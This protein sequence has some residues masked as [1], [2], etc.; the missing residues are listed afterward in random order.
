MTHRRMKAVA[1]YVMGV[2]LVIGCEEPDSVLVV[3]SPRR[4][5]PVE[6][7]YPRQVALFDLD[8]QLV[9]SEPIVMPS[10]PDRPMRVT[11]GVR[12]LVDEPLALRYRFVFL[13]P[14]G[15]PLRTNTGWQQITVPPRAQLPVIGQAQETTA[16]DWHVEIRPAS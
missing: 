1:A 15:R 6:Q 4:D 8:E 3:H 16:A 12:S 7:T 5:A 14:S 11:L 13:D 10:T 2:I 9:P